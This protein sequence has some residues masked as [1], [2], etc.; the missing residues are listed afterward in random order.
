MLDTSV[1]SAFKRGVPTVVSALRRPSEI[2]VPV[3]GLGELKAGFEL[4]TRR[5]RNR[6]ELAEFLRRPRV[7]VVRVDQ[8]TTDRYAL[9]H[10]ELRRKGTPLPTNDLWIAALAIEHGAELLTLDSDFERIPQLLFQRLTA[11]DIR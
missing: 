8:S 9:L 11:D 10:A 3:I 4:G 1:Y 5:D 6:S 2:L 7:R